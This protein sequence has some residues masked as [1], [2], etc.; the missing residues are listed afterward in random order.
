MSSTK[1]IKEKLEEKETVFVANYLEMENASLLFLSEKE[2]KFGT[3]AVAIPPTGKK[4][5]PPISSALLGDKNVIV[6]R[7]LAER[8]AG[9]LKKLALVS[10]FIE[11]VDE[12]EAGPIL[13]RLVDK[14][15]AKRRGEK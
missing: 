11:S 9:K 12:R 6:A 5:G 13:I 3:L 1:L 2:A 15:L 14:T 4:L 10:V 7:L 8:L